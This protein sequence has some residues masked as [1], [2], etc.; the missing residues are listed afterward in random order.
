[1][2]DANDKP[3]PGEI[4]RRETS[5][6]SDNRLKVVPDSRWNDPDDDLIAPVGEDEYVTQSMNSLG[7]LGKQS[8]DDTVREGDEWIIKS[9]GDGDDE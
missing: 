2:S 9:E 8:M 1:M 4:V 3:Q 7:I 6:G 5:F